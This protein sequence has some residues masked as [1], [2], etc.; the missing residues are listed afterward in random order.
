MTTL[1]K[2]LEKKYFTKKE[3]AEEF[4]T[5]TAENLISPAKARVIPSYKYKLDLQFFKFKNLDNQRTIFLNRE[6]AFANLQLILSK[7]EDLTGSLVIELN[8]IFNSLERTFNNQTTNLASAHA[9]VAKIKAAKKEL[10]NELKLSIPKLEYDRLLEEDRREFAQLRL[11]IENRQL[12]V[13]YLAELLEKDFQESDEAEKSASAADAGLDNILDIRLQNEA[14]KEEIKELKVGKA[15]F[16]EN[17]IEIEL[18]KKQDKNDEYKSIL[19]DYSSTR[20][21]LN[22]ANSGSSRLPLPI[23][24]TNSEKKG[25]GELGYFNNADGTSKE[26]RR[27]SV[28]TRNG[29][30]YS[31]FSWQDRGAGNPNETTGDNPNDLQEILLEDLKGQLA[32]GKILTEQV[33]NIEEKIN[34]LEE[35]LAEINSLT[36]EEN[37]L[38]NSEAKTE[39]LL[40]IEK[41]R[42]ILNKTQEALKMLEKEALTFFMVLSEEKDEES[43]EEEWEREYAEKFKIDLAKTLKEGMATLLAQAKEVEQWEVKEVRF[44]ES[45]FHEKKKIT[46]EAIANTEKLV[47]DMANHLADYHEETAETT[48]DLNP[49][50]AATE[51]KAGKVKNCLTSQGDYLTEQINRLKETIAAQQEF[52]RQLGEEIEGNEREIEARRENIKEAERVVKN[53]SDAP[54]V[55]PS[56]KKAEVEMLEDVK[57]KFEKEREVLEEDTKK[58]V[59]QRNNSISEMKAY[60]EE[61]D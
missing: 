49:E 58:K 52:Q 26:R 33:K 16:D 61:A 7:L 54:E 57:K 35:E 41:L 8:T 38:V 18:Q 31:T 25:L 37:P 2:Y 15:T 24:R 53:I 48:A 9:K 46:E 17:I 30:D 20:P 36:T 50:L 32:V 14:L 45:S 27:S 59:H 4:P 3:R 10:K 43:D 44:D 19:K 13:D 34:I 11:E 28:R 42:V 12:D 55:V 39:C 60:E 21:F 51:K 5:R 40:K 1:Q 23:S 47:E 22:R 6:N 29:S 56:V